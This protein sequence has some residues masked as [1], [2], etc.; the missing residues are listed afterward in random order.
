MLI[1][2]WC[3]E[4][5]AV[6]AKSG[7]PERDGREPAGDGG[8]LAHRGTAWEKADLDFH[9]SIA[10]ASHNLIAMHIMEGLKES[11]HS[12][13]R[14]KKFTLG[15]ERKDVLHA[16]A[17]GASYEAIRER[18]ADERPAADA[19]APG[20]RRG[21]DPAGFPPGPARKRPA[22]IG[23][24]VMADSPTSV[25]ARRMRPA[26]SL[27]GGILLVLFA[28]GDRLAVAANAHRDLP[29]RRVRDLFPLCLGLLLAALAAATP[30]GRSSSF[31]GAGERTK[32]SRREEA[33][34]N[35]CSA[36]WAPCV[37]RPAFSE[38]ARVCADSRLLVVF[39]AAPAAG[40]ALLAPELHPCA[41][42]GHGLAL[43]FSCSGC[44]SLSHRGGWDCRRRRRTGV[45][46]GSAPDLRRWP[47]WTHSNISSPGSGSPPRSPI[48]STA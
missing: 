13:F 31:A 30:S 27:A 40:G 41:G 19:G 28:L 15:P 20:V 26:D 32:R 48:C 3:A 2:A 5:A 25:R 24:A 33:R 34:S 23:A 35:P 18:N 42:G 7:R 36:S 38:H 47:C 4:R 9:S 45:A 1:E 11:F 44:R 29:V 21:G 43:S 10:A 12:Y 39:G 6:A 14:A 8:D 46:N 16:A 37:L 22:P 17:H